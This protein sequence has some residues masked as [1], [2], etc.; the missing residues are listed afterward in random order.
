MFGLVSNAIIIGKP[1]RVVG[2]QNCE[3]FSKKQFDNNFGFKFSE[4][5]ASCQYLTKKIT[6]IYRQCVMS[7]SLVVFESVVCCT[8]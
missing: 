8:I 1:P 4:K 6:L 3:R 7:K 5:K 2:G